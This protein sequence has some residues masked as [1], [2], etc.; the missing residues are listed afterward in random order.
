MFFVFPYENELLFFLDYILVPLII[1]LLTFVIYLRR[2]ILTKFSLFLCGSI[3]ILYVVYSIY[4]S[5]QIINS[6]HNSPKASNFKTRIKDYYMRAQNMRNISEMIS[7]V[8]LYNQYFSDDLWE[9]S[10][11]STQLEIDKRY[12]PDITKTLYLT[13]FFRRK[14]KFPM[15]EKI[16]ENFTALTYLKLGRHDIIQKVA[17]YTNDSQFYAANLLL[18][19]YVKEYGHDSRSKKLE[20]I[21]QHNIAN[22]ETSY[23]EQRRIKLQ[24]QIQYLYNILLENKVNENVISAY[25]QSVA[26][27]NNYPDNVQ[28]QWIQDMYLMQLKQDIF[29]ADEARVT[30]LKST[31][32]IPITFVENGETYRTIWTAKDVSYINNMAY[33][34]DIELVRIQGKVENNTMF[35]NNGTILWHIKSPYAKLINNKLMLYSLEPGSIGT[36]NAPMFVGDNKSETSAPW[37]ITT[38]VRAEEIIFSHF[39]PDKV[40]FKTQSIIKYFISI[41]LWKKYSLFTPVLYREII[42][43]L[44]D[45]MLFIAVMYVFIKINWFY[46]KKDEASSFIHIYF[47]HILLVCAYSVI[48]AYSTTFFYSTI[49]YAYYHQYILN[50]PTTIVMGVACILFLIILLET[51]RVMFVTVKIP[52]N[53]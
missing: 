43:T 46:Y 3:A 31:R 49:D 42:E 32:K 22:T 40:F 23:T 53:E 36:R 9:F 18:T 28:L 34:E 33:L 51:I 37:Y 41:P 48:K 45:I 2:N 15:P 7:Y 44:L 38:S 4:Y 16:S 11:L 50:L 52:R 14:K 29:F 30:L 26:L 12:S 20:T 39:L 27:G 24:S 10:N 19:H 47:W 25:Y 8:E 6:V 35:I 21:I 5:P 1:L 13:R 17:D